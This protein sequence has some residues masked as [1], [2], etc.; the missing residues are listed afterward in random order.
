[1][2][3]GLNLLY[4]LPRVVGGTET[5][6][7]GLLK[8][9]A[10]SDGRDDFVVFLNRDAED[11]PLPEGKGFT[12][13]VCDVRASSRGWRYLYEQTVLPRLAREYSLDVVH[14][15]GYTCP[16]FIS[17][18]SVVTIHDMNYVAFGAT[19]PILRRSALRWFV[20][21]GAQRADHIITVSGFS[22]DEIVRHLG[23][24]VDKLTVIHEAPHPSRERLIEASSETLY[25][26]LPLRKPYWVAFSSESPNKNI[27]NL[28]RA[29]ARV[30][31]EHRVRSQLVLIG[32][33]PR[34]EEIT[35]LSADDDIV[36]TGYISDTDVAV[37]VS[38]AQLMIFPSFYEG[39]GLPVVE[40]MASGVPV[41]CSHA[42][43]LPEVAGDAALYFDPAAPA[44]MAEKI[45]RLA[46]DPQLQESMK[47]KGYANASRFSWQKTAECTIE[48]YRQVCDHK[49]GEEG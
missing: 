18:K 38:G 32:H 49:H 30:R 20:R 14:S 6:A 21:E 43:S 25:G 31:S 36:W 34:G 4:L 33:R 5:Y 35:A 37:I 13:V 19:F 12:R 41:A 3:I 44:D 1:M 23:V 17:C 46:T 29:I 27:P 10:D 40:A 45:A 2:R 24:P 9:L 47:K 39:F 8:G 28:L 7:R 26:S 15:L 16:L 11:W 22:R 42:A 48:V